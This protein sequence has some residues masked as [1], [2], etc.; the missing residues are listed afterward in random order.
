MIEYSV[1]SLKTL[2]EKQQLQLL[3]LFAE[4][5]FAEYTADTQWLSDAVANSVAAVGAFDTGGNLIGFAR[6]LGDQVSDCYIQ[7]VAVRKDCRQSGISKALVTELLQILHE[8]NIDWVG[9]IA[10]PGKA[11][12]YRKLGFEIMTDHTPMR[13]TQKKLEK[14]D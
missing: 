13:L 5:E 8:K 12:F 3:E 4:V 10:T 14:C 6:A 9:L 1:K 2:S 11:E 7:D